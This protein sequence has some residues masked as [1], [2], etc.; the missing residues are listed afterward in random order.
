[1]ARIEACRGMK[2][3]VGKADGLD[4]CK[5][6]LSGIDPADGNPVGPVECD[7]HFTGARIGASVDILT[8]EVRVIGTEG[9]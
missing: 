3:V 6:H 2:I 4:R 5:D 7:S 9:N 1:M 8:P